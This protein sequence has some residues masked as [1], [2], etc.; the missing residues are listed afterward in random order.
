MGEGAHGHFDVTPI[1]SWEDFIQVLRDRFLP[2]DIETRLLSELHQLR[3]VGGDFNLF[4]SQFQAYRQHLRAVDEKTMLIAFT[5]GLDPQLSY[6]VRQGKPSTL[7]Q[8][9]ELAWAHHLGPAPPL[10]GYVERATSQ[11]ITEGHQKLEL[12]SREACHGSLASSRPVCRLWFVC[13][14]AWISATSAWI[15][16]F[17]D[18]KEKYQLLAGEI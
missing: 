14:G 1:T 16:F 11:L 15:R 18:P 12:F 4:F 3:M 5:N 9:F 7:T 10:K 13:L 17:N 6:A 2:A 8:A